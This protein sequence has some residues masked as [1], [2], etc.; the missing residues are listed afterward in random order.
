ME[1]KSNNRKS[2][3]KVNSLEHSL[4]E[5]LVDHE[6]EQIRGGH[7]NYSPADYPPDCIAPLK[8]DMSTEPFIVIVPTE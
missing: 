5:D 4:F 8:K 1:K 6:A 2:K 3:V 7:S